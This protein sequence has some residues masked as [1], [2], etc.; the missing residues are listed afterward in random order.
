MFIYGVRIHLNDRRILAKKKIA[1]G[2]LKIISSVTVS[3]LV[4]ALSYAL[5]WVGILLTPLDCIIGGDYSGFYAWAL[6]GWA[7]S[8]GIASSA[9]FY[10]IVRFTILA[11]KALVLAEKG[12]AE[13]RKRSCLRYS[14]NM[15][16]AAW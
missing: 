4:F 3:C 10:A 6:L 9:F 12:V 16:H 15:H 14:R 2:T 1:I 7:I 8:I 5:K 13:K 11:L